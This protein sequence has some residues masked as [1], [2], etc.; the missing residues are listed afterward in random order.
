[1]QWTFCVRMRVSLV[2]SDELQSII[3]SLIQGSIFTAGCPVALG[4]CVSLPYVGSC[5]G[6]ERVLYL[7]IM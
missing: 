4:Q 1:M 6:G 5:L 3:E 2:L 7:A